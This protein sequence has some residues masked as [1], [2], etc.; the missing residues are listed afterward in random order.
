MITLPL[1]FAFSCVSSNMSFIVT[2]QC[3]NCKFTDCVEVCP[4]DCFYEGPNM[5]VIHPDQC[6]DCGLC[7]PACPINAIVSEDELTFE[8]QSLIELNRSYAEKWPNITKPKTSSFDTEYWQK[9]HK[10]IDMI[11]DYKK[12]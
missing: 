6:I 7:E 9:Q 5:V 1:S 8:Q 3:V 4:V 2:E 12:K 11:E 10:T